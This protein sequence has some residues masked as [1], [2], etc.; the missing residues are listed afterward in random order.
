[1][2]GRWLTPEYL[3][4]R[5][6]ENDRP[7][8]TSVKNSSRRACYGGEHDPYPG[9][10]DVKNCNGN[11][12]N[13]RFTKSDGYY[14]T[15]P[16]FQF[17]YQDRL[18]TFIPSGANLSEILWRQLVDIVYSSMVKTSHFYDSD[19]NIIAIVPTLPITIKTD[20]HV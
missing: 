10:F 1:M 12:M 13:F 20:R 3:R 7:Y 15:E 9:T 16:S 5:N 18:D 14:T 6:K 11:R 4:K 19:G 17:K 2:P 8:R